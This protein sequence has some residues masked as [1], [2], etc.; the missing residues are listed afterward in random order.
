MS[1]A[2]LDRDTRRRLLLAA[3]ITQLLAEQGSDQGDPIG[4]AWARTGHQGLAGSWAFN[5]RGPSS[6]RLAG[7]LDHHRGR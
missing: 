5:P 4:A 3:A 6:W 2:T 7:R 1:D